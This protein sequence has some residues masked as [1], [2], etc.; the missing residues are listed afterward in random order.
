M[1]GIV[2]SDAAGAALEIVEANRFDNV[3]RQMP[4]GL[5]WD[6]DALWQG[7]LRGLRAGVDIA[8]TAGAAVAGIGVD[9]WG[10]DYAR[11]DAVGSIRPFVRHHRDVDAARAAKTSSAR[12]VAADYAETGILDQAINTFHQLYQDRAAGIGAPSDTIV[13][14]ADLFR[15]LLTGAVATEPSLASTTA[16]VSRDTEQ[17]SEALTAGLGVTLPAIARSGSLAGYTTPAVTE[18]IGAAE[19]VPV[20]AVTG[21]DTAAAFA[22]VV[23]AESGTGAGVVSSGS[24]SVVGAVLPRPVL[25]EAARE[26]GFTQEIGGNGETLLIKNLSGMWLL[27][28]TMQEWADAD[29][30]EQWTVPELRALLV[31]AKTSTYR[32]VFDPADPQLQPA[33]ALIARLNTAC[34]HSSGA[35]PA[36]R[37]DLVRA[38]VESLASSYA[39]TLAQ[40]TELTGRAITTVRIVGGGARND[41][42]AA[43]T[44]ARTG[45]P[46]IAGPAEASVRGLV[47]QL[48]VAAGSF[49]TL[50]DAR[51]VRV[52]GSDTGGGP[53]G[54]PDER[55]YQ[56]G[57]GQQGVRR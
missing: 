6:I 25:T 9:S 50:A 7:V 21:H 44:A 42:L 20:W 19:P 54:E 41:L 52:H 40:I 14:I 55:H 57:S 32:G 2:R 1:I 17:W 51:R 38:I 39:E 35:V 26:L 3:P 27:Q 18:Q 4:E 43:L 5:S 29:G 16:L 12:N 23:D 37:A 15:Y 31:E 56:P 33:G 22:A 10:V 48:A 34:Q 24:W 8:R 30:R 36:S 49:P 28:R 46:V 13:L 11:R 53:S 47:L 45:L